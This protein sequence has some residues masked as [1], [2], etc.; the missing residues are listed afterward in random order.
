MKQE[1]TKDWVCLL[2]WAV[3]TMNSQESSSSSYTPHELF[4]GGHPVWFFKTPFPEEYKSPV[5]DWLEHRQD[6]VNLAR[7]NLKHVRERESASRNRTGCPTTFNVG[8]LVLVHHSRLPTWPRNCLQDPYFGPYRIIKMDGSRIHVRCS[9]RLGGEL[10]CAP[11]QLRHYHSPDELSWDEWHLSDREVERIDLENA[12]NVEE[13]DELEEMT[14]NQMAV[15]GYYV[16]AVIARYE[17]KQGWNFLTLWDG[18]GLP[19]ATWEP[20]SAFIQP[21]GSI[22]PIFCSYLVEN[23]EGQLPTRAETLSQRKKKINLL[24]PIY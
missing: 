21:D 19:E 10:L 5:A 16:V 1:R 23:N 24:V 14:A 13:A 17:Y 18:Y 20:M 7:A 9:P 2:P 8:D 4:H 22:D 11:K 15:D 3:L 6:L 12:A